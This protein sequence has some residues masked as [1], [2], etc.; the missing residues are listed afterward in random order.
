VKLGGFEA[1]SL[2]ADVEDPFRDDQFL[3]NAYYMAPEQVLGQPITPSADLYALGVLIYLM[4]LL[5]V[6]VAMQLAS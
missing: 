5:V 2:P 4:R 6:L 3:G 1:A